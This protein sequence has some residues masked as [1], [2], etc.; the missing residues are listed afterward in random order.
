MPN[1]QSLKRMLRSVFLG[2][3]LCICIFPAFA[4][5]IRQPRVLLIHSYHSGFDW[6]DSITAGV[7]SGFRDNGE[8]VRLFIEYMDSKQFKPEEVSERFR[9]LCAFK[10]GDIALDAILC[11][12]NNALE[13]LLQH[14]DALFPGVPI[15]FCG[16]NH[17]TQ[18]MLGGASNIT[19]VIEEPSYRETVELALK[20]HPDAKRIYVLAGSSTTSMIHVD[21]FLQHTR[22][23]KAPVE[24]VP[25]ENLTHQEFADA[26]DQVAKTDIVVHLGLHRTRDDISLSPR[27][28]YLFIREHT[29]APIYT[30]W[31]I[32]LREHAEFIT[33]GVMIDGEVQGRIVAQT[34]TKII[35]GMPIARIPVVN[36][37]PNI[38]ILNFRELE[39]LGLARRPIPEGVTVINRPFSFFET[40][41][42][43]VWS[44]VI[45]VT[46]M[47]A[48]ILFLGLSIRKRR[49]VETELRRQ[50]IELRER[51][52][53]MR[54]TLNSIAE[55][56]IT[57]DVEGHVQQ[58]NP[59]A[60]DLTGW[61]AP[62]V[63]GR[64]VGEILT[65]IDVHTREP[66]TNPV[67]EVAAKGWCDIRT[68]HALL[69]TRTRNE[70]RINGSG[71]PI[72]DVQGNI[73]GVVL[74]FR[75]MT[76]D[77][78]LQEKL[79]Q[80]QKMDAIGQLAG[81]V[82]HD[83]NNML[84]GI[85]ASTEM[86]QIELRN[87][88]DP[89]D[90]LELILGAADRAAS[91]TAKLLAFA[92]R[93]P[94][95]AEPVE[96]HKPLREALTLF[97]HTAD[98]R[99]RIHE[100]MPDES[101]RVNG[102]FAL[103]QAAFLNLFINASHAMPDGG[104]LY[105]ASRTVNLDRS[106]CDLSTFDLQPGPFVEIE[107]RDTGVGMPESV[108]GRIFEP[109][110][111]TKAVGK[112]TGLGLS[113]VLGTIQQHG[114]MITAYS[115]LEVGTAFKV[116]LPLTEQ[117]LMEDEGM[118]TELLCGTGTILIVD[119]ESIMRT[120]CRAILEGYG[121]EVLLA[122]DGIQGLELF[123]RE[124]DRID[125]VILDMV[126]PKMNG[127]DCFLAIREISSDVP[128]II[129]SGFSHL[130]EL[131]DLKEKGLYDIIRKPFRRMELGTIVLKALHSGS[132]SD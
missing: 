117:E 25:I 131:T 33:G 42:L 22:N 126:M 75:D 48:Q 89:S 32:Y 38:P 27:E 78:L 66:L 77:I 16:I 37:S 47:A 2:S 80:G 1:H 107:I 88:K 82:A 73:I 56:V 7:L 53:K 84:G 65:I 94:I 6:T 40:Y 98:K 64:P 97:S 49:R 108:L 81:G 39:R 23:L 106:Y 83:F 72:R 118:S 15:V 51:E 36:V 71:A 68:N 125:L 103:L 17:F 111:T 57:T 9:E 21:R 11:S 52:E 121:Y 87:K 30:Y 55:A 113:A 31:T 28:T 91:L 120:T 104:D 26:L 18:E 129:S 12:D 122:E 69:V 41:R 95:A 8:Q 54:V 5:S 123:K 19:G 46:G 114:G 63:I 115:E 50:S 67:Q 101:L 45:V 100:E 112:G 132:R 60:E 59:V 14:R 58:L 93:Q 79:Q 127:R 34:A 35:N 116:T 92:R 124:V 3:L 86:A 85:I 90:L 110:F 128:V 109:F 13:F 96:I 74:V 4:E 105:I 24:I 119:D 43:L 61:S 102:D 76:E 130:E 99:I 62:E 10:Y 70:Y 44:V 29:E 20:V